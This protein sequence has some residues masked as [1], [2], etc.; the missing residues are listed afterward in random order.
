VYNRAKLLMNC[1]KVL[2]LYTLQL[3]AISIIYESND[4][5]EKVHTWAQLSSVIEQAVQYMCSSE[6]NF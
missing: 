4:A 5:A 2:L 1:L 3:Q 6:M